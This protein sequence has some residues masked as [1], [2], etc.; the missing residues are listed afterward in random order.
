MT[1][2]RKADPAGGNDGYTAVCPRDGTKGRQPLFMILTGFREDGM[3]EDK[4]KSVPE[5]AFLISL[6]DDHE[7]AY[8]TKRFDVSKERLAEALR[9]VGHSA[10]AVEEFLKRWP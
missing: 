6:T 8:W 7:V 1:A 2:F 5:V 3:A 10:A 4:T 9:R